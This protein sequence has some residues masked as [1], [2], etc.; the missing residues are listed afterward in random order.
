MK[1]YLLIIIILISVFVLG[2]GQAKVRSPVSGV[3]SEKEKDK[4]KPSDKPLG[5]RFQKTADA[6]KMM[7]S[8]LEFPKH[9]ENKDAKKKGGEFDVMQYFTV[10]KHIKM[11]DGYILDY[12][13][14]YSIMGGSPELYARKKDKPPF[15]TASEYTKFIEAHPRFE[16]SQKWNESTKKHENTNDLDKLKEIIAIFEYYSIGHLYLENIQIDRTEEGYLEFITLRLLGEQFYLVWHDL[17]ND[18]KIIADEAV[19]KKVCEETGQRISGCLGNYSDQL[20]GET[21]SDYFYRKVKSHGYAPEV[22]I[23]KEKVTV[24]IVTFTKW[25]GFSRDIY[26]IKKDF[27]HR[28]LRKDSTTIAHYHCGITY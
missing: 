2:C 27:P 17:Y 24:S 7:H 9:F 26:T 11:Q 16:E 6:I 21:R 3:R 19:L 28:I 22:R 8:K 12:V 25:R 15:K 4:K 20:E 13:Y 18:K 5:I 23:G 1:K 10:F 14:H